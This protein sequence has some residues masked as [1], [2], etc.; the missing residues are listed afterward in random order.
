MWFTH[1]AEDAIR[2]IR[3]KQGAEVKNL[4]DLVRILKVAGR[5]FGRNEY[6]AEQV[7]ERYPNEVSEFV[8]HGGKLTYPVAINEILNQRNHL[9]AHI[10]VKVEQLRKLAQ[11]MAR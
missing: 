5:W 1:Q 9:Q 10:T 6:V 7:R 11:A 8:L 2:D 3:D 4:Y